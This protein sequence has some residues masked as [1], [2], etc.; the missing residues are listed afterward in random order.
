MA[1]KIYRYIYKSCYM[2]IYCKTYYLIKLYYKIYPMSLYI[3][4]E[5]TFFIS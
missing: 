4:T 2:P 1:R 5:T 3:L